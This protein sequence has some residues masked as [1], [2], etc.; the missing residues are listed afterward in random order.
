MRSRRILPA[1]AA[2][3]ALFGS[4]AEAQVVETEAAAEAQQAATPGGS[5]P[6]SAA[7]DVTVTASSPTTTTITLGVSGAG[8]T[9][10]VASNLT[11]TVTFQPPSAVSGFS[12]TLGSGTG[13]SFGTTF[14]TT[15]GFSAVTPSGPT[16]IDVP[17]MTPGVLP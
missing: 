9:T 7:Q 3:V 8:N 5:T 11:E 12:G 14:G 17:G 10:G 15:T 2:T 13:T 1:L 4:R 16:Y 6:T